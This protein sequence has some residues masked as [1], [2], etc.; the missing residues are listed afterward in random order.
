MLEPASRSKKYSHRNVHRDI[1]NERDVPL[2]YNN[3]LESSYV[4]VK[5]QEEVGNASY[6]D[7][8]IQ[9]DQDMSTSF[10]S[11]IPDL[12]DRDGESEDGDDL[13]LDMTYQSAGEEQMYSMCD[14]GSSGSLELVDE[15]GVNIIGRLARVDS[16]DTE[17]LERCSGWFDVYDVSGNPTGI[18]V[19]EFIDRGEI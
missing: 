1:E 2:D 13:R 16:R 17:G 11:D 6:E 10:Q 7:V 5:G 19:A 14:I 12:T 9:E 4:A 8:D 15:R 18:E 3:D